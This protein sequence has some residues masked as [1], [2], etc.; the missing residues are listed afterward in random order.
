MRCLV[1]PV[2]WAPCRRNMARPLVGNEKN[3][4]QIWT[5]NKGWSPTLGLRVGFSA[6]YYK[7]FCVKKLLQGFTIGRSHWSESRRKTCD[8]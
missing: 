6:H 2:M 1:S 7:T 5:A 3:R 4:L 8:F